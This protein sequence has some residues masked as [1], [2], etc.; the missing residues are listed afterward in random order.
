MEF[1]DKTVSLSSYLTPSQNVQDTCEFTVT[2]EDDMLLFKLNDMEEYADY[3]CACNLK[4]D[5]YTMFLDEFD[6][7]VRYN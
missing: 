3:D 1:D 4:E 7:V 2:E 5:N 6:N